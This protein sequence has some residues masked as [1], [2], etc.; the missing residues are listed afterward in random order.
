LRQKTVDTRDDISAVGCFYTRSNESTDVQDK[1]LIESYRSETASKEKQ[2]VELSDTA[3]PE[4]FQVTRCT[5][6]GGQLDL[7]SVHFMCKHSYHQRSATCPLY[8]E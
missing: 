4:V 1:S 2:I 5:A 8:R 6:C 7:P 3:H